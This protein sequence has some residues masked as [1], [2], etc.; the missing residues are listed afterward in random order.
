V[1]FNLTE[2]VGNSTYTMVFTSSA[3]GTFNYNGVN[4]NQ[5]QPITVTAGNFTGT[6]TG[7]DSGVHDVEFTVTNANSTPVSK[8]DNVS[9]TYSNIDFNLTSSGDGSLFVNTDKDFN[10][11]L[12]QSLTDPSITYQVVFTLT[13]GTVGDGALTRSGTP[14]TYGTAYPISLGSSTYTFSASS[15]GLVNILATVTDSN[16]QVHDTTVAMNVQNI[17]FAFSG[18]AQQTTI[19]INEFTNLNFDITESASSGSQYQMK[20]VIVN[21]SGNLSNGGTALNAN[22]WY[23]VNIGSYSWDFESVASG[24]V[25]L[26]FTAR[27]QTTLVEHTQSIDIT[28]SAAP[29][30]DFTFS[31]IASGNSAVVGGGVPVNFNLTQ[32]VGTSSYSMVFTSSATGTFNYNGVNYNQGQPITVTA[33][34]FTGTYTG[35]DSGVHD[36]EFTVTNANSTP[37]SRSDNV[38]ITYSN[39]DF[40]LTSSGDGS[41]F[42]NTDKD[43]NVFLSQSLTDPSITY[44]VVFTLTTGT[45]GDG[46]L[47]RSGTPITYGTAYPISLGSSTYTFSASSVGL[48]NILATVT[49]SNGQVHDTTVAMNVQNIDFAF[50]GAAQQTTIGINEFTNLNFDI[51]ESAS[52]GSQYQMKYVIVSGSGNLS[53]GGTSLNANVWYNVNIGSYSW[54]FESVASGDVE[55]LFTARNQTTLVEHTQTIDITVSAAPPSDFTFS[56]IASGNSAVVGGG[57]PV[58]FNLTQTVGTSSYSMVFTSSATGTFNY[59]GVNYN[60]GQPITVTAGNFTG[61]YT[62]SDSGVHDVEFT[63]TNANSTPV[64][65]VR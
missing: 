20:Y 28:V 4:Y 6:Y 10:V 37:V 47:T 26:L 2:T 3:T 31:A 22:V 8:S 38:S 48:V 50:S 58:N 9:I 49:D 60:Q 34:N 15:V 5:G 62:G 45:V 32:T 36:V 30:S 13:T 16:G 18:A 7:S 57:V 12:S 19:G 40:N 1:N 24:D 59:N 33:G 21:G 23:N 51:T 11:F 44:Q 25:E 64:S 29:P 42:V 39:I 53:N 54:D 17:D 56:A 55:L 46:A 65:R 14:I 61:T 63:V 43:F 41:L 27:N 52:S 35:S